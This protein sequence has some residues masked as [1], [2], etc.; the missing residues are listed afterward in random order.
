MSFSRTRR[1]VMFAA[2]FALSL[3]AAR[4]EPLPETIRFGGFGQG[5][6][7]PFGVAVL[8]IAHVK[9]LHRR[10]IQ[11]YAGEVRMDLFHRNWARHQ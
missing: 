6:G 3:S 11:G 4:A 7:K 1:L 8:A 10:R 9:G 5:F 2:V